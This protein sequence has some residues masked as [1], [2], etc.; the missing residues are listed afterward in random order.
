[1]AGAAQAR[2]LSPSFPSSH[3]ISKSTTIQSSFSS[4]P[5]PHKPV[6]KTNRKNYLRP[7]LPISPNCP[8][9]LQEIPNP[10]KDLFQEE[11]KKE[12]EQEQDQ[13]VQGKDGKT[14][15]DLSPSAISNPFTFGNANSF[16]KIAFFGFGL[17]VFQTICTVWFLSYAD[18]DEKSRSENSAAGSSQPEAVDQSKIGDVGVSLN[19]PEFEKKVSE[20]RI[21][22]KE[23]RAVERK[24]KRNAGPDSS[25]VVGE[26]GNEN[27]VEDAVSSIK[28]DIRK[29]VDQRLVRL[30]KGLRIRKEKNLNSSSLDTKGG[31]SALRKKPKS[32]IP[33]M[34]ARNYPKGFGVSKNY[35][36]RSESDGSGLD[37]SDQERGVDVSDGNFK[38]SGVAGTEEEESQWL[39]DEVFEGIVKKVCANEEAGRDLFGGLDSEEEISFFR[40]LERKFER[41][42]ESAK[43]WMEEKLDDFRNGGIQ[44]SSEVSPLRKPVGPYEMIQ[45]T[46]QG[47]V[48]DITSKL[49]RR[50]ESAHGTAISGIKNNGSLRVDFQ[51]DPS[52]G[53]SSSHYDDQSSQISHGKSN[54]SEGLEMGTKSRESETQ[55]FQ[56]SINGKQDM[57]TVS[58]KQIPSTGNGTS[59][60]GLRTRRTEH[61]SVL[62]KVKDGQSDV[63]TTLWWLK[64]PHVFAILLL[65]GSDRKSSNGL[66]SLKMNS[67]SDVERSYV[68]TFEG[69]GDAT[70]MC[71]ILESFFQDLGD[72]SAEAIPLSI[73]NHRDRHIL[74][75]PSLT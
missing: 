48:S 11:G 31:N 37:S 47:N 22:A 67:H 39:R 36:S 70:N 40:A 2:F 38:E 6:K 51:K 53:D 63:E 55:N 5:F 1:M 45:S 58:R 66:Y 13:D 10:T 52:V 75:C 49:I 42:G 72:F 43:Q 71:C 25:S 65:R 21:M 68:I 27:V 12:Q 19:E 9:P 73:K 23:A 61:K 32:G 64:L 35:R 18:L 57:S 54:P 3:R 50:S 29:E 69:R 4:L 59:K 74:C 20:I 56:S 33:S 24:N 30:Q 16:V 34:N 7:K 14:E 26:E 60:K 62:R 8:S 15:L 28:T 46:V 17:F 41:E 44:E